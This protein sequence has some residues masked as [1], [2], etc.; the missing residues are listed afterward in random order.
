MK[1]NELPEEK[2]MRWL[3]NMFPYIKNPQDE[4]DK[5]SNVIHI[6][7]TAAADKIKELQ[8]LCNRLSSQGE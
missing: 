6:Y 2:Q 3:A 5:M 1:Q 8:E 4:A 7:C